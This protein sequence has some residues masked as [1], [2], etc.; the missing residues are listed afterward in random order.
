MKVYFFAIMI[1]SFEF[2]PFSRNKYGDY[3]IPIN[4]E[5][6]YFLSNIHSYFIGGRIMYF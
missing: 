1:K 5:L 3:R 6:V 4:C 2:L